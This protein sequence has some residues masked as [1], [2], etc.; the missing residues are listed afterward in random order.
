MFRQ[1]KILDLMFLLA[2]KKA[3]KSFMTKKV[4]L[5]RCLMSMSTNKNSLNYNGLK[6]RKLC[7]P[8][9]I[10]VFRINSLKTLPER[11]ELNLCNLSNKLSCSL[12]CL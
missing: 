10:I 12:T 11:I 8:I 1:H 6:I 4:Q 9:I 3:S 2:K 7:I 5:S